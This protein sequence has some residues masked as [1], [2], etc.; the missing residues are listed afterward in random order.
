MREAL[1]LLVGIILICVVL[2]VFVGIFYSS[3]IDV[4]VNSK[5]G[6]LIVTD[7]GSYVLECKNDIQENERY[8]LKVQR[9]HIVVDYLK[10]VN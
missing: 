9:G 3:Y 2:D 8:T 7:K 6:K 5:L 10:I 1:I 4:K